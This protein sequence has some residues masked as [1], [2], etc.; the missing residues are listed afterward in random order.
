M[1]VMSNPTW[2]PI[3]T[4]LQ[5][6]LELLQQS[7][8]PDT[9]TQRNVQE[10]LDQLNEHP[11]FCNYLV[12]ILA[13]LTDQEEATRSLSGLILKNTIRVFWNR[14]PDEIRSFVKRESLVAIGDPSPLIRATVGIIVTNIVLQEGVVRWPNL[15]PD[16]CAMLDSPDAGVCEGAMGALQKICE[17]SADTL[18]QEASAPLEMLI[19]KL[20]QFFSSQTPKIRALAV[21]CVNCCLL[22]QCESLNN[23][24]DAFLVQLFSLANDTDQEVQR[25]LCRALTLLLDCHLEKLAPQLGNIVEFM[26]MR[27]QDSDEHTAL[28]ACEFWLALAENPIVCKQTLQNHLPK[29]IPILVHAMKYSEMDILLLKGDVEEDAMVP[30]RLEDIRP[31]FHRAK[32]QMQK[33]MRDEN[34]VNEDDDMDDGGDDS[35][36]EWNLRKCAA[37]SLDVLSNIFGDDFLPTLLPILK[38]TLFHQQW[39]IK[40]SGILALGAVAEGC[41]NGMTTHLP[42]LIPYLIGCLQDR[43]ALVRSITCWTLSR[44]CHYVVQQPHE[45]YFKR[46]LTELLARILDRNK[47]VQEAACSAFATLEEEACMELVPDLPEILTTLVA[48][49]ERYQAKNLLI[50]YDAVGTLADSVGSYLNNQE[51]IELLMPPLMNKWMKLRDEDKELFP[52]LECLSSVATAL[53]HGFLPYCRPVFERCTLLIQRNL[54]QSAAAVQRPSEVDIPEKDFLIV[55]LDLLSGLAEGLSQHIEPLVAQSNIMQLMFQCAQD[56]TPEVRQSSFALLGDLA[57]ACYQ[58]VEPFLQ[59]FM[60]VLSQNLNPELISVC[61]NSIWAIGE[62]STKM[63]DGM[64]QYVGAFLPALVFIINRDKTPKT[65]LENTAITLGRLGIFC[66][67]EVAPVLQQF[68]RPWCLALRNIRDNDEKES[69]FRGLCLMINLNPAGVIQDF[70]FLCDAIASWNHPQPDLKDM[71]ARILHG[72]RTQVGETNWNSFTSQFPPPL[73]ERLNA[74]YGV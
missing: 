10:R 44:Y 12:F 25:Q 31:R 17:D 53:Q 71:F 40:E 35:S 26:L 22:V 16:L 1:T 65:L 47:R 67:A 42:E 51:Y 68:I 18:A 37:A 4:E 73:K 52:L 3:P 8:S 57:K 49:F 38:E 24:I 33:H 43:K 60:P 55:A 63:G 23:Y 30:D 59:G 7:Q 39:E 64:R 19:P 46:L 56:A 20:L 74:Q 15:L 66:A 28:E 32:T 34:E 36:T 41:M 21:N 62:I 72:F 48:A 50:L 5:Q 45:Q 2:Q 14:L 61:N 70:I 69:A 11:Q 54:E 13:R 58:H 6:V 9:Q 29:L 27:T